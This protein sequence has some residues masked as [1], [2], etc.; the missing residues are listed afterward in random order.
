M[1][2]Q[3]LYLHKILIIL[4]LFSLPIATFA[5]HYKLVIE[6][7][8]ID[9]HGK[10]HHGEKYDS[11]YKS[12][13]DLSHSLP[14]SLKS[15]QLLG[16]NA[17]QGSVGDSQQIT[18][19]AVNRYDVVGDD[20]KKYLTAFDGFNSFKYRASLDDEWAE[21]GRGTQSGIIKQWGLDK[22]LS[23]SYNAYDCIMNHSYESD[24]SHSASHDD[25]YHYDDFHHETHDEYVDDD[26]W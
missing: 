15:V 22:Y 16:L 9:A 12:C 18:V 6:G 5:C 11:G 8:Y 25:A 13:D 17:L 21:C 24:D 23:Q 20:R 2:C 7:R 3:R 19:Y 14:A 1:I 10:Y 4:S 26:D